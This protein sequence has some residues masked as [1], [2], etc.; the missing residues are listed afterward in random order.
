MVKL[1]DPENAKLYFP[2]ER[3]SILS[4]TED[5]GRYTYEVRRAVRLLA[6]LECLRSPDMVTRPP[7][8]A[9]AD[10]AFI[11]EFD[12]VEYPFIVVLVRKEESGI[13]TLCTSQPVRKG[14]IKKWKAGEILFP[15][16]TSATG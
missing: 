8:L 14:Q 1:N 16:N 5:F 15:K 4:C 11:K 2:S 12:S 10:R 3:S 9:T 7:S 13:L 6:S